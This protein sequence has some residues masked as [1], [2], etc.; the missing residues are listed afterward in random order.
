MGG[1]A[2][3]GALVTGYRPT[4]AGKTISGIEKIEKDSVYVA[5]GEMVSS[6]VIIKATSLEDASVIAKKCPIFEFGGSVEV[7]PLSQTAQ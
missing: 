7:R 3:T 5:N 4:G 6:F 1:L 2:Q